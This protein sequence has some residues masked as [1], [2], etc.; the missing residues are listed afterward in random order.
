MI[1]LKNTTDS[2]IVVMSTLFRESGQ[3]NDAHEIP[4]TSRIFWANDDDVLS[5]ISDGSLVLS[6]NDTDITEVNK[7]INTLKNNLPI[8]IDPNSVI[9]T[10][11]VLT[12]TTFRA[13]LKGFVNQTITKNT[14][15]NIDWLIPQTVYQG[16]NKQSYMDGIEYYAKDAEVGDHLTFQVID[17]DNVLGYGANFVADE[18]GSEWAAIPDTSNVIKLYKAKLIPGLY[19]RIIYTSTGTTND[20]KL[21]CNL[22]RHMDTNE[23]V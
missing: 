7:A 10:H 17:K 5:N 18:F 19:I 6:L 8:E 15:T 23:N 12:G 21:I 1:K 13:R 4:E 9:K 11:G 14:T 20:I 2:E 16:V 3:D 22:F